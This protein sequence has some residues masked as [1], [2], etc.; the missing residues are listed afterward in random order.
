MPQNANN[1][2]FMRH[3]ALKGCRACFATQEERG[4]LDYDIVGQGR[5]HDDTVFLRRK[6]QSLPT[7]TGRAKFFHNLGMRPEPPA[8]TMLYK[9]INLVLGLAYYL[10]HS[11]CYYLHPTPQEQADAG[12]RK[13][14][15]GSLPTVPLSTRLEANTTLESTLE[16]TL[17]HKACKCEEQGRICKSHS[18]FC[19]SASESERPWPCQIEAMGIDGESTVQEPL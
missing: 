10:P 8:I 19:L 3:N 17:L 13:Q 5:Y 12:G 15:Y 9:A 7:G 1:S 18:L 4:D 11:H 14:V 16:S 2:G 6:G